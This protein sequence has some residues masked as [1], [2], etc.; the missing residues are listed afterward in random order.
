M[1]TITLL[2]GKEVSLLRR[3]Q[4]VFSGAIG[5]TTAKPTNGAVV[6]VEAANGKF[7]GVGHYHDGSIAVRIL[8]FED[9]PIDAAFWN[10]RLA[11]ALLLRNATGLPSAQTNCFRLVHGEGD[12]LPGLIID[13][14]GKAAVVQ[15]HTAAMALAAETISTALQQLKGLTLDT[16]YLRDIAGKS[17]RFLLGTAA[18]DVVLENGHTFKVNWVEGQKTGFFLDQRDNRALLAEVAKNR[19]VLNTFCYTGG[20]SAY[21]LKAGATKVVSVDVSAKAVALADEN[22]GLNVKSS[23]NHEA[24]CTDAFKYLEH[25]E[26][27]DLIILDPPAFAKGMKARHQAVQGYKRL[28][29]IAFKRIAPNGILFTFSCSQVV[30]PELFE[31]TVFSA[32]I[33]AG[34]EVRILKRLGH[35]ADHPVSIYHPEGEYLKGLM[36]YVS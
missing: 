22:V 10:Q 27:F 30:S 20:F 35:Q 29:E 16:I 32:A 15:A 5:K 28:N 23:K 6:R 4:W 26:G 3:H 17:A 36:L 11:A 25:A 1:E 9:Q 13:V 19:T 8:S 34:R 2:K 14:Y 31:K 12:G 33:N 7:L 18:E 21:A 24:V